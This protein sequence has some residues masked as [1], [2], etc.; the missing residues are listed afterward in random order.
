[1]VVFRYGADRLPDGAAYRPTVLDMS[2]SP[3]AAAWLPSDAATQET[4]FTQHLDTG[5]PAC[6]EVLH[7][8]FPASEVSALDATEAM[9]SDPS[10]GYRAVRLRAG[11]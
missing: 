2:V 4:G 9:S 3:T 8:S 11:P 7:K 6:P 10:T 5:E 1:M